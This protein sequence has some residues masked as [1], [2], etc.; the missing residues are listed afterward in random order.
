MLPMLGHLGDNPHELCFSSCFIGLRVR[1]EILRCWV[2][3][4]IYYT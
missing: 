3:L 4:D 2:P 1:L